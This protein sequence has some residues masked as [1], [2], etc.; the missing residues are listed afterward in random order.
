MR[1]GIEIGG[2]L[3][4]AAT[5]RHETARYCT[6]DIWKSRLCEH[7]CGVEACGSVFTRNLLQ[8]PTMQLQHAAYM[9]ATPGQCH[10]TM[11][12]GRRWCGL[13][14]TENAGSFGFYLEDV[15]KL[16]W[17][18]KENLASCSWASHITM[19]A[20]L[21]HIKIVT[22]IIVTNISTSVKLKLKPII[23]TVPN[24]SLN[25]YKRILQ[26]AIYKQR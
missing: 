10:N 8:V 4:R 17:E 19:I 25:C 2:R 26:R 9:E 18:D 1:Y 13:F 11:T 12:A 20:I 15:F 6:K 3:R 14:P 5:R 16:D 21:T 24:A 23:W 22:N 7:T